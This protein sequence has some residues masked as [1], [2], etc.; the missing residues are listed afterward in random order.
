MYIELLENIFWFEFSLTIFIV[1]VM[2]AYM[3]LFDKNSWLYKESHEDEISNNTGKI[4]TWGI[5]LCLILGGIVNTFLYL[6]KGGGMILDL[7]F[8]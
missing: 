8:R 4:H 6:K 3:K 5:I 7:V 2:G 1:G